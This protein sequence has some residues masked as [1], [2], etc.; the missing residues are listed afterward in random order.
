VLHLLLFD[1]G[2]A[3][4][5][6][7]LEVLLQR[8]PGDQRLVAGADESRA[9]AGLDVL[10]LDDHERFVVDQDLEPVAELAGVDHVGHCGAPED[11]NLRARRC[12]TKAGK[13][14]EACR[15][16]R[17]RGVP[18][19]ACPPAAAAQS[20]AASL[21]PA[22]RSSYRARPTFASGAIVSTTK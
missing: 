14:Q 11:P 10:E 8:S 9:L 4:L 3:H 20:C 21:G 15:M 17:F 7:G 6:A 2:A 22:T 13:R 18:S 12:T 19:I 5:L 1:V 16:A